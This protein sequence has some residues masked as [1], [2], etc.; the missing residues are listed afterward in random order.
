MPYVHID[1]DLCE[2]DDDELIDEIKDRGYT[3]I[4]DSTS[5]HNQALTDIYL[6]RRQGLPYDHLMDTYI[7]SVLGKVI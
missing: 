1:V 5:D 6:K 3:V 4:E 2:F 7:Y